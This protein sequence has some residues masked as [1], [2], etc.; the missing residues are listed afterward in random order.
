[1]LVYLNVYNQDRL[2]DTP[3][4]IVVNRLCK[5]WRELVIAGKSDEDKVDLVEAPQPNEKE[6]APTKLPRAC[7]TSL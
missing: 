3:T 2:L 5:I 7:S 4:D 1:M 6:G